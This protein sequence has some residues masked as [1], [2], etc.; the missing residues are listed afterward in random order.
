MPLGASWSEAQAFTQLGVAETLMPKP[1]PEECVCS[2]RGRLLSLA[3]EAGPVEA[4]R[5]LSVKEDQSSV[6]ILAGPAEPVFVDDVHSKPKLSVFP[7]GPVV[8]M[9]CK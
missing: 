2:L 7:R 3:S 8:F 5:R 6:S 4:T 9:F 1:L